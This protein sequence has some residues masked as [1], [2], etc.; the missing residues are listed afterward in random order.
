MK[1]KRE[2][3]YYWVK[4]R[5]GWIIARWM[6]DESW[7]VHGSMGRFQDNVF[8]EINELKITQNDTTTGT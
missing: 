6:I 2:P 3:G 1:P 7:M 4:T 5:I 8:G